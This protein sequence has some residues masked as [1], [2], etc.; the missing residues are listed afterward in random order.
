MAESLLQ[1]TPAGLYCPRGDF[2]VDP[3][4]PVERAIITHAHA[5]HARRGSGRYLA[6]RPGLAVLRQRLGPEAALDPIDYG[7]FSSI[8][9]VKVSLHPAGHILGSS[10]VRLESQGE[11]W[12]VSGDYK[13]APDRTCVPF[14]PLQCHTYVTESTFGLPIYRWPEQQAVFDDINAWW[15]DNQARGRA[16][17]IYAYALGKSQRVLAGIDASIGPIFGHGAV[18]NMHQAYRDSGVA[19]PPTRLVADGLDRAELRRGLILAPP[20]AQR[21]PWTRRFGEYAS[22]FVSGWMLVRGTRRRRAVDRGFVLSDHAD[23]PGL[24]G[25]IGASGAE[26]VLV[27][28]GQISAMVRWLRDQ[29][30]EAHG[31]QT[32]FEGELDDG[33]EEPA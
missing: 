2:H 16:S 18:E 9:G 11:V 10:Q 30:R 17:V 5:D 4:L 32:R 24:L 19:L 23:W 7:E 21:S 28:H 26:R 13:T 20:S 15:G 27:T 31:L 6:A 3:W 29:G 25:A 12:V 22:A 8:N 1:L 14:E 33:A